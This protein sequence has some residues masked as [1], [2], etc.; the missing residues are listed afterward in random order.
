MWTFGVHEAVGSVAINGP[1]AMGGG[2]VPGLG[3]ET[4]K[5]Q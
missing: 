5:G 4:P 3:N 2:P 1:S